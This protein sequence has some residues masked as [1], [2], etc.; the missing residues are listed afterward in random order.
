MIIDK[1]FCMSSFLAFRYIVKENVQFAQGLVH[2]VY[3][4]RPIS[5]KIFVNS[6]DEIDVAIN[7]IF[8]L[9]SNEKLGILLSGG[10][11]S[12]ILASYLP[13]GTDA[14]TFRFMNGKYQ[15][16][17]LL[18]AEYYAKH[19]NLHLHYVDIDWNVINASIPA[20]MKTKGCPVHSIE[21][22]IYYA[23]QLAKQD[24]ITMMI[25][26][27]GADYVFG[28]MDGLL[29][30]DWSFE[31]YY[32]RC[33]Y[34]EPSQVLNDPTDIH[35]IFENYRIGKN[36]ID[37]LRFYNEVI[38]DESYSSYENAFTAADMPYIDPYERLAL[39]A[40]LDLSR[41]RS[42]ESKYL[43]RE[44]FSKKYPIPV[45]PKL[46]MP[47]PVDFYLRDWKGPQ[48]PEFKKDIDIDAF[49]GNQKWLLFCLELFLNHLP[50]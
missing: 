33:I 41:I 15:T 27:D 5:E 10:M 45:P 50:C 37:F 9:V 16:D 38:T 20:V 7:N 12:A 2:Q 18:R 43:I 49:S 46:P 42:G 32:K 48:R 6:A 24:G 19:Y 25:V 21:P 11:D 31:D 22:Q 1:S 8:H 26:G 44:L 34:I 28:G 47:R 13:K 4:Q 23:T 3:H 36:S 29:S 17:E 40:P 35:E 14:Y 39:S 30:K